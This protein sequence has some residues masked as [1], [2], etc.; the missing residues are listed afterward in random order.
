MAPTTDSER[1][2]LKLWA[3]ELFVKIQPTTGR[4]DKE[5]LEQCVRLA[6]MII[7]ETTP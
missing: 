3:L 7:K 2:E 1:D 4:S 5:V 6:R